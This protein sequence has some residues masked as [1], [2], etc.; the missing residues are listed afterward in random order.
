M[1]EFMGMDIS[2]MGEEEKDRWLETARQDI[3][4]I[5]RS[6]VFSLHDLWENMRNLVGLQ[7]QPATGT[8]RVDETD[9]LEPDEYSYYLKITDSSVSSWLNVDSELAKEL[10]GKV[11]LSALE[12]L[13]RQPESSGETASRIDTDEYGSQDDVG[14]DGSNEFINQSLLSSLDLV[15]ESFLRTLALLNARNNVVIVVIGAIKRSRREGF[16]NEARRDEMIRWHLSVA[17]GEYPDDTGF[18]ELVGDIMLDV[19]DA[20]VKMQKQNPASQYGQ[21]LTR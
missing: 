1:E 3:D 2:A 19:H 21:G 8:R 20:S 14:G 10:Y 6:I 13:V 11:R 9:L 4:N 18:H 17:K 7:A 15:D 12:S 5:G 16:L